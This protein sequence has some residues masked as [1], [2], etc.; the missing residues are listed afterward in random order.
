MS[1]SERLAETSAPGKGRAA[2]A[3]CA[4]RDRAG[5]ELLRQV[6]TN[7]MAKHRSRT[8]KGE[9]MVAKTA[10]EV[11]WKSARGPFAAGRARAMH[12]C[13]CGSAAAPR[14]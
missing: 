9:Q 8:R 14:C 2:V 6:R 10:P 4:G 13:K 3:W 11:W 1:V 7:R 12:L 5:V